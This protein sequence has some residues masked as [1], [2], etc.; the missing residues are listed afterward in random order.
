VRLNLASPVRLPT[1]R[2]L[3]VP[4]PP[5]QFPGVCP[6]SLCSFTA[7]HPSRSDDCC[8]RPAFTRLPTLHSP[9]PP[10]AANSVPSHIILSPTRRLSPK[11]APQS[12]W[13]AQHYTACERAPRLGHISTRFGHASTTAALLRPHPPQRYHT[14]HATQHARRLQAPP[15][16]HLHPRTGGNLDAAALV[17]SSLAQRIDS[18]RASPPPSM[19]RCVLC[20]ASRPP[21][22]LLRPSKRAPRSRPQAPLLRSTISQPPSFPRAH[23]AVITF[24]ERVQHNTTSNSCGESVKAA[25][26]K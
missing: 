23:F 9:L 16:I 3:L 14:L 18:A 6:I 21:A 10:H 20:I 4:Q 12:T 13:T 19:L 17:L 26:R 1:R 25:P 2:S 15:F 22:V 5:S 7:P 11:K 8:P 24:I